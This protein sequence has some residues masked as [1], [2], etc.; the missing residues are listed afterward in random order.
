VPVCLTIAGTDSGGGAGI[1]ADLATFGA[2]GAWGALAVAG[3]TAQD[4]KAV[5][6]A[7]AMDPTLVRAQ[8]EA[9][10]GDIGV[11]AA[12]TGMLANAA[13]VSTVAACVRELSIGPLVVDPVLVATSGGLLLEDA[14]VRVLL[15]QLVPLATVLT[16]N[17]LEATALTGIAVDSRAAAEAAGRALLARGAHAVL[18]K[19]GHL[20]LGDG[21][22][23]D[24]LVV[25]GTSPVWFDGPRL[26]VTTTHGTGCVLSAAITARLARGEDLVGA[27]AAAK[28]FVVRAM[29]AGRTLGRGA[30]VLDP[31]AA[32]PC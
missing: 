30:G 26:E 11:Q 6:V 23:P 29:Q 18:V 3:V 14:A 21:R 16:P 4:T 25:A 10:V 8:I 15:E 1:S 28:A 27:V 24:C 17:G 13:I 20:D 22:S 9:V 12:K 7:A 31:R 2:H 19:G 5:H 32:G